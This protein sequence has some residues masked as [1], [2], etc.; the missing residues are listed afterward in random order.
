MTVQ[1]KNQSYALSATT[2]TT[3]LTIDSSSRAILK[4]IQTTN[5]STGAISVTMKFYDSSGG[6][7]TIINRSNVTT[8]TNLIQGNALVLEES[9]ALKISAA[10]ASVISGVISYALINRSNEKG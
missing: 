3:V 9:D 1:Y 2:L 7:N 6:S 5:V 8:V 4:S 10:T